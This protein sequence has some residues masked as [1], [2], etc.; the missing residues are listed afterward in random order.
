MHRAYALQRH[1]PLTLHSTIALPTVTEDPSETIAISGFLHLVD[2]FRPFDD[3]FVGL[4]NKA[5]SDCSTTWLAHLQKQLSDALPAQLSS[6]ESQAADLRISQQW[7]RTMVWQLSMSNGFLSS[8]SADSSMKF[9][10]PLEIARD[11]VALTGQL[12]QQ[13]MEVH[14]IGLV[15]LYNLTLIPPLFVI[16]LEFANASIDLENLR[17]RVYSDGRYVLCSLG[18]QHL[19]VRATGLPGPM[20][21][22]SLDPT[23]RRFSVSSSS[24]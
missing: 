16:F 18:Q 3:I 4:W 5:R 15:S 13:S 10:Y 7:L 1:R 8:A 21:E 24:A 11:L 9:K 23:R 14:G 22:S 12:S 19:R 2:L 6:T 20:F 17:H